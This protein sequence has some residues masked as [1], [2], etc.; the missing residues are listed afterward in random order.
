M[1]NSE[2]ANGYLAVQ[3]ETRNIQAGGEITGVIHFHLQT[4][5]RAESLGLKFS[6]KEYCCWVVGRDDSESSATIYR[7]KT[8]IVKYLFPLFVFRDSQVAPGDY[9]FPF[10]IVTPANLPGSFNYQFGTTEARI[11]YLLSGYLSSSTV[12]VKRVKAEVGVTQVM[13]EVIVSLQ[14][15]VSAQITTC[16]CLR[17]GEVKLSATISK[18]AYV[19][20]EMCNLN[21]EVDNSKAL[22]DV[23][24]FK[25]TLFRTI[26][27]ISNNGSTTV[28]KVPLTEAT[29]QHRVAAGETLSGSAAIRMSLAVQDPE[30]HFSARKEHSVHVYSGG[31]G[32]IGRILHVLW[33]EAGN[34]EGSDCV[35]AAVGGGRGA[36][37]ACRLE[38]HHYAVGAVRC[39]A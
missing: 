38:P 13:S 9:S 14:D 18:S 1:G 32:G 11:K 8:H 10:K 2:A 26:R 28:L 3:A 39:S 37:G 20:G 29:A 22:L 12:K 19:P 25:G 4:P 23:T 33:A 21:I 16:C 31:E 17:K 30:R 5:L 34:N 6:G 36:A 35:S 27:L 7:G 24:A 15:S